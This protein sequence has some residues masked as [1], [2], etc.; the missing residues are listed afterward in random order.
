MDFQLTN[1]DNYVKLSTIIRFRLIIKQ[2]FMLKRHV[3]E[4]RCCWITLKPIWIHSEFIYCL[5]LLRTFSILLTVTIINY[6][7]QNINNSFPD[8]VRSYRHTIP[9]ILNN[10]CAIYFSTY[11]L[12]ESIIMAHPVY[13]ILETFYGIYSLSTAI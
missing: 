4:R 9:I 8:E 7:I 10:F 12:N 2:S 5:K 6:F 13:T 3:R 11:R 1:N